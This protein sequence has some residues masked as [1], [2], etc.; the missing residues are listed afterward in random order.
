MMDNATKARHPTRRDLLAGMAVLGLE[1]LVPK[2]LSAQQR[3]RQSVA[4]NNTDPAMLDAYKRAIRAMLQ[5]PPSDPRNWYRQALVH[6]LDCPHRNWW[7][8]PWHR[9]YLFHL[10]QICAQLSNKPDFALPF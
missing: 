5:L 1:T 3:V 6:L 8:L 7:F 4:G 10:E 2:P 9:G